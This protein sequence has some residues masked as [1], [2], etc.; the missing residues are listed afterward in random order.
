MIRDLAKALVIVFAF[1]ILLAEVQR[2][3]DAANDQFEQ[4]HKLSQHK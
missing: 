4:Q 1:L 2:F 3:D